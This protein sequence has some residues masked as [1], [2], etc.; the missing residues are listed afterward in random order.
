MHREPTRFVRLEG[1]GE[2]A[3]WT[4]RALARLGFGIAT[5]GE[6]SLAIEIRDIEGESTWRVR[7][8]GKAESCFDSLEALME[9]IGSS[10]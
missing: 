2:A 4:R 1:E 10:L 8:G 5:D 6:A 3:L 7:K 9:W